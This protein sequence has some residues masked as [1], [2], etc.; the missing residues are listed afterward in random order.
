MFSNFGCN[1]EKF[2]V[3]PALEDFSLLHPQS[4][5]LLRYTDG[6]LLRH[7]APVENLSD[8]VYTGGKLL[9][10]WVHLS[11]SSRLLGDMRPME[12]FLGTGYTDGKVFSVTGYAHGKGFDYWV[13]WWNSFHGLVLFP[14]EIF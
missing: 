6:K 5:N 10:Y 12:K 13:Q 14:I 11:K 4:E 9:R 1:Q 7:K 3:F 8:T 2:L